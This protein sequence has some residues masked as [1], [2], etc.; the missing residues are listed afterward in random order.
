M[1]GHKTK[2]ISYTTESV[3]MVNGLLEHVAAGRRFEPMIFRLGVSLII[4]VT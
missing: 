4:P 3:F 2:I 1:I